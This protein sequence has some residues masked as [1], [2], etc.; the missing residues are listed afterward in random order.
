[1]QFTTANEIHIPVGR[2]V[3]LRLIGSDVIHSFWVPQLAGKMDAIPGQTNET[4]IEADRPGTYRG[5]CTE[6]CGLEHAR[7]GFLVVAQSP[8]EFQAWWSHQVDAPAPP[9]GVAL[10]G[11]EDFQTHCAGCHAV[12]GTDAAGALGPDLSHLMQRTTIASGVLPNDGP[13]LARWIS[14]PQSLKPGSLMPAPELSGQELADVH[15]YLKTLD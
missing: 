9:Q 5:Q 6:Y 3:R 10:A 14:D 1:R 11:Q 12:R 13:T 4:W 7:M 8:A 15:A 2:P